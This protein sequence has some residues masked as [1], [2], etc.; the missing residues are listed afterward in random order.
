MVGGAGSGVV[1]GGGVVAGVG[2]ALFLGGKVDFSG[3]LGR[4]V[5]C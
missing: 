3:S 4:D 5:N 1:G 2:E